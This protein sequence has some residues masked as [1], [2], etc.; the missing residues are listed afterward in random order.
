VRSERFVHYGLHTDTPAAGLLFDP[1][2]NV[3]VEIHGQGHGSMILA[4]P[5][6]VKRRRG[7][8]MEAR[9]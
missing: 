6:A 2:G 7:A 8:A 3:R 1:L 5:P 4:N 9:G